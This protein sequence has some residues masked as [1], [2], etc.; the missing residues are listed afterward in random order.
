M[1]LHE[2]HQT[3]D[4]E[5]AHHQNNYQKTARIIPKFTPMSMGVPRSK[6]PSENHPVQN[7]IEIASHHLLYAAEN[8]KA[9]E[10]GESHAARDYE[11]SEIPR[12]V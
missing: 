1:P 4:F 2:S 3:S 6:M 11:A 8:C 7:T 9:S 5:I 10:T 12:C